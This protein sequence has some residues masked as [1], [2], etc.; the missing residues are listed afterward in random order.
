MSKKYIE[1]EQIEYK[2][3]F[4]MARLHSHSHFELYFLEKG[5]RQML[6]SDS[7]IEIK[8]N[9]LVVIPPYVMHKTEGGPCIRTN[10][11]IAP[12]NLSSFEHNVLMDCYKKSVLSLSNDEANEIKKLV[13][14]ALHY[15][16]ANIHNVEFTNI[17]QSLVHYLI[18]LLYKQVSLSLPPTVQTNISVPPLVLQI[19]AYI[20]KNYMNEISLSQLSQKFY[21]STVTICRQFKKHVHSSIGEY[22]MD[23]RLSK[24]KELL[25]SDKKKKK[26]MDEIATLC[27]FSSANYFSLI[28]KQQIGIAP[29]TY[30]KY[31]IEK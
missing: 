5:T 30:R 25:A 3:N 1:F 18:F 15:Y 16:K 12:E 2:Q 23:L 6:F 19:L 8:Q 27:G 4:S 7:L 14:E 9:D 20:N 22:L 21:V 28:F 11:N 24:A 13:G 29:S 31:E 17:K 26:S 10:V